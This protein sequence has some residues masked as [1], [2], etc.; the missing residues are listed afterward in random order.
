[1]IT[2]ALLPPPLNFLERSWKSNDGEKQ[3]ENRH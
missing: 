1:M 2:L 3:L